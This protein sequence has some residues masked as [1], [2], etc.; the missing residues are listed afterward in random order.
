MTAQALESAAVVAGLSSRMTAAEQALFV[1][2]AWESLPE[3]RRQFVL[4]IVR[5]DMTVETF[6]IGPHEPRTKPEDVMLIHRLWLNLTR[7]TGLERLHHD[8]IITA[9]LDRF[10]RDYT[11]KGNRRDFWTSCGRCETR[12]HRPAEL[13]PGPTR[14]SPPAPPARSPGEEAEPQGGGVVRLDG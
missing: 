8:D 6:T 13:P 12:A 5:P 2:R 3:P 4:H 9:A 10:S 1:G 11:G 14:S 7:E